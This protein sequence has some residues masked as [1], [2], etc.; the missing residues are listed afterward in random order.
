MKHLLLTLALSLAFTSGA[1][2]MC[3]DCDEH[4]K[5]ALTKEQR[6]AMVEFHK[7]MADCLDSEKSMMD[8]KKEAMEACKLKGTDACP[9]MGHGHGKMKGKKGKKA[10]GEEHKH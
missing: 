8:C 5:M 1:Y 4:E 3:K 6:E 10:G 2:S 7:K 9:F